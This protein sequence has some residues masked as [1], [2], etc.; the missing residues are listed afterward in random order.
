MLEYN[1]KVSNKIP[2]ERETI[3]K[4]Q[5]IVLNQMIK[6]MKKIDGL[7]SEIYAEI[8]SKITEINFRIEDVNTYAQKF[9]EIKKKVEVIMPTAFYCIKENTVYIRGDAYIRPGLIATEV[10]SQTE[11]IIIQETLYAL[12]FNGK[13]KLGYMM[14]STRNNEIN[15]VVGQG[16]NKMATAEI[17]HQILGEE[18]VN[19]I[20]EDYKIAMD[21]IILLLEI[22]NNQFLTNYFLKDSWYN[23]EIEKKLDKKNYENEPLMTIVKEYDKRKNL[24]DF[25]SNIVIELMELAYKNKTA[26]FKRSNKGKMCLEK[27]IKIKKIYE[28]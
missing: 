26:T 2:L 21:I 24:N 3:Q 16:L 7:T 8:L 19:G 18:K 25:N 27:I 17:S 14:I 12:A 15:K 5:V 13:D 23:E 4:K 22:D 28:L 11:R 20:P 9:Y 10:A 1:I 6:K